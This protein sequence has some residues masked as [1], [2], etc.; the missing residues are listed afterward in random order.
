[1]RVLATARPNEKYE[2]IKSIQD[3]ILEARL[4]NNEIHYFETHT[5]KPDWV[6]EI[7]ELTIHLLFDQ[8]DKPITN[9]PF[10]IHDNKEFFIVLKRK[11]HPEAYQKLKR[12][13]YEAFR[14]SSIYTEG[15]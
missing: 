2:N 1:M 4:I 9:I 10:L 14:L 15:S 7:K 12:K 11:F 5:K 6:V 8:C 13:K 3:I